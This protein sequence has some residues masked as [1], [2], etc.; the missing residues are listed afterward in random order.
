[1]TVH[2]LWRGSVLCGSLHGFPSAWGRG[3][4]WIG[5]NDPAWGQHATC[6]TCREQAKLLG[7]HEAPHRG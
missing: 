3:I 6:P 4:L 1:M 5:A 7:A 2:V